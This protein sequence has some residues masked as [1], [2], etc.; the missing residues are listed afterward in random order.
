MNKIP[1][2]ILKVG[3]FV[4]EKTELIRKI[5]RE[6]QLDI[7]QL[8]GDESPYV[9]DEL[10]YEGIEL[11]KAFKISDNFDFASTAQYSRSCRYFLFDAAGKSF[12][13]N[14]IRFN[15]N[16]LKEYYGNTPFFLS[17][18]INPE[19]VSDLLTF[20][21]PF[22]A[23]IDLNS[24]FETEPGLKDADQLINFCNIIRQ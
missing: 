10:R 4:N 19:S 9:C 21:H 15:W 5:V 16:K 18:G 2:G 14:G 1:P 8:H 12:G 13:G 7:V 11:I 22:L 6:F 3:V 17:G 24:G 20:Y 23:G